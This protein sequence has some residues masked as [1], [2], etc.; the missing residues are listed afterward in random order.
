MHPNQQMLGTPVVGNWHNYTQW[1]STPLPQQSDNVFNNQTHQNKNHEFLPQQPVPE[2]FSNHWVKPGAQVVKHNEIVMQP[3]K[4][5]GEKYKAFWFIIDYEACIAA[6]SWNEATAIKYFPNYLD[7]YSRHWFMFGCE[8][9]VNVTWLDIRYF[10][11]TNI[12]EGLRDLFK[13]LG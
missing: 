12:V 7:S 6:N 11:G 3:R 13:K 4:F 8:S 9:K 10:H 5:E 1:Q 2:P